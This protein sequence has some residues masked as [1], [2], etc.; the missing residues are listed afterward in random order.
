MNRYINKI[1]KTA[2]RIIN[3]RKR[4]IIKNVFKR[5]EG[6]KVLI[7]YITS[8]FEQGVQYTHSNFLECFTSARIFDEIGYQVDVTNYNETRIDTKKIQSYDVIYGFG[9]PLER[10][11]Y[12]SDKSK[13]IKR[14]VYLTGCNPI[15]SNYV[16]AVRGK[17]FQE[18][19][20]VLLPES[21]RVVPWSWRLQTM[22]SDA[23]IVLGNSFVL[24]TYSQERTFVSS[25]NL[26]AFYFDILKVN[27][28]KKDFKKA[29][30]NFLWFGSSGAIHKGL[31][32]VIEFFE[33]NQEINLHICGLQEKEFL[34]F[35]QS[36]LRKCKNIINHG[37]INIHSE[38]FE[39]IMY[40]CGAVIFPSA[41][42]GGAVS[43]LNV[44]YN[45]GLFPI[46]SRSCGLDLDRYGFVFS[47][48][49]NSNIEDGINFFLDLKEE[50]LHQKS[51]EI[52]E[53]LRKEYSYEKYQKSIKD[54][55]SKI[56]H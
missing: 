3:N 11:F 36:R 25:Y 40:I 19:Y 50:Q 12:I 32:K 4:T 5:N 30:K 9:E 13:T 8:P 54:I 44:L 53:H 7:S 39:D 22:F 26:N 48:I 45:G 27:T 52:I 21:L 28:H 16:S 2:K 15:Y 51:I 23:L 33:N 42:E 47:E 49:N 41:S 46:I 31:D 10:S 20:D 56:I 1:K 37:F 38:K 55:I 43:I 29:Q 34:L 6:K 14:I 35:F 24:D 18:K 17:E